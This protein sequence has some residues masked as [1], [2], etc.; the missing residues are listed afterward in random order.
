MPFP[1]YGSS[2]GPTAD[3]R[4]VEPLSRCGNHT[5]TCGQS[6][7]RRAS[8]RLFGQNIRWRKCLRRN[9]LHTPPEEKQFWGWAS[10]SKHSEDLAVFPVQDHSYRLGYCVVGSGP[11]Q[12]VT[13]RRFSGVCAERRK[14]RSFRLEQRQSRRT[15][16][17]RMLESEGIVFRRAMHW[18]FPI[19][20]LRA[21]TYIPFPCQY[22]L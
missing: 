22:L 10:R 12:S 19:A 2:C 9:R 14:G 8:R 21:V 18:S 6:R 16:T 5:R 3:S 1:A 17:V 7:S 4:E 11:Q 15:P 20:D 13:A